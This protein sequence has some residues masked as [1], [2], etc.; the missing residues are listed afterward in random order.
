M[1]KDSNTYKNAL[2]AMNTET[3]DDVLD[4]AR[5]AFCT[6][7]LNIAGGKKK[8]TQTS[9]MYTNS[10]ELQQTVMVAYVAGYQLYCAQNNLDVNTLTNEQKNKARACAYKRAEWAIKGKIRAEFN[11]PLDLS[12]R[13]IR[14]D[15]VIEKFFDGRDMEVTYNL[16]KNDLN[17]LR[18]LL[19]V[20]TEEDVKFRIVDYM[21]R[22]DP[23]FIVC[24]DEFVDV[25]SENIFDDEEK[26]GC[27]LPIKNMGRI[28]ET[29]SEPTTTD[30]R[31]AQIAKRCGK[32]VNVLMN[33]CK[34]LTSTEKKFLSDYFGLNGEK[35][36]PGVS[37]NKKYSCNHKKMLNK[38]LE[39]LKKH[40]AK[41][42]IKHY[43]DLL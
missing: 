7:F 14:V 3:E 29:V 10:E 24:L 34:D 2:T 27:R 43:G 21:V 33:N 40:Y 9:Y 35:K 1:K 8:L 32:E 42:G 23:N 28:Y 26:D 15:C 22:H 11:N 13:A 38:I 6:L 16:C 39:K 36:L 41:Q 12:P 5:H 18:R 31:E 30:K 17:M 37:L 25:T 4:R 20:R 19:K